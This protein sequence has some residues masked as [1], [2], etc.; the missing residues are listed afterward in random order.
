M[1]IGGLQAERLR[2]FLGLAAWS[3]PDN[4]TSMPLDMQ[5]VHMDQRVPQVAEHHV[6]RQALQR[7]VDAGF[8]I[9]I[10]K[11]RDAERAGDRSLDGRRA[12]A[13]R[14]A[15][16]ST[17]AADRACAGLRVQAP[18]RP[19]RDARGSAAGASS[20]AEPF[21]DFLVRALT[22]PARSR[23]ARARSGR[24][25]RRP[26]AR[27]RRRTI[28]T[29]DFQRKPM[30]AP[31]LVSNC[32]LKASPAST[33]TAAPQLSQE[34]MLVLGAGD[35][36]VLAADHVALGVGVADLLVVEAADRTVAAGEEAQLRRQR[37]EVVDDHAA[38]RGAHDHAA[39]V[40]D[41]AQPFRFGAQLARGWYRTAA[42]RRRGAGRTAA[43]SRRSGNTDR[44]LSCASAA[45]PHTAGWSSPADR[46]SRNRRSDTAGPACA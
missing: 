9:A 39:I 24:S 7:R 13:C 17:R 36:L 35:H 43:N 16:K 33:K 37:I 40:A 2:R 4:E 20:D 23:G 3:A 27:H 28:P 44:W 21:A 11:I 8:G 26:A 34:V 5:P 32:C 15:R 10:A 6:E 18:T 41:L 1:S 42:I 45:L 19:C 12:R 31:T 29:G 46:R 22:G 14:R 25:P 38:E 30:P